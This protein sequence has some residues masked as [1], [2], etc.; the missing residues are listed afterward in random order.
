MMVRFW[1]PAMAGSAQPTRPYRTAEDAALMG[2][3]FA[4]T[5]RLNPVLF[6]HLSLIE[7]HAHIDAD[8]AS[9]MQRLP[10]LVFSHGYLGAA[11]TNTALA[12][13]LASRGFIVASITHP[14]ESSGIRY[15]NGEMIRLHPDVMQRFLK[16]TPDPAIRILIASRDVGERL[17]AT[18]EIGSR[19][20][21]LNFSAPIWRDDMVAVANAIEKG[22]FGH[23][24]AGKVAARADLS[25]LVYAGMSF[26]GP[27]A[28]AACQIDTRCKASAN[29]DGR[30]V[31]GD[32]V[33]VEARAPL[34]MLYQSANVTIPGYR[35]NDFHYEHLATM[36]Q[37]ADVQR[38]IVAGTGH[39]D[40]T[41]YTLYARQ[42]VADRMLYPGLLGTLHGSHVLRLLDETVYGFFAEQLKLPSAAPFATV[43]AR[44]PELQRQELTYVRDWAATR[45][46]Q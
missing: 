6:G 37:R 33:D 12:E 36:G 5:L 41:D 3:D 24:V 21:R 32:F 19:S 44:F 42:P 18:Q 31:A 26:G 35:Y 4:R 34:L 10:L 43:T 46:P 25:R 7:T 8:P 11:D 30:E 2:R 16:P 9:D 27:A 15:A 38:Y 20:E 28:A 14:Y 40:F 17:K 29:L 1:Y 23:G 45:T 13:A 22:A 39:W